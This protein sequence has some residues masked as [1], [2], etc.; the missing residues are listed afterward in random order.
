MSRAFLPDTTTNV[1]NQLVTADGGVAVLA[2]AKI[3]IGVE[4]QVPSPTDPSTQI[5][6]VYDDSEGNQVDINQPLITNENG[7]IVNG[8]G[9][10]IKP[11]PS[12][13]E[14]KAV[15][16][17]IQDESGSEILQE[18]QVSLIQDPTD[19]ITPIKL[20]QDISV[21][22]PDADK[23]APSVKAVQDADKA[24]DDKKLDKDKVVDSYS[25]EPSEVY[26][27]VYI[28]EAFEN[29]SLG[30]TKAKLYQTAL[31]NGVTT[32][33]EY[34]FDVENISGNIRIKHYAPGGGGG[35]S[36][37]YNRDAT[38]PLADESQYVVVPPIGGESGSF[39]DVTVD[40]TGLKKIKVNLT[41]GGIGGTVNQSPQ[42]A[43]NSTITGSTDGTTYDKPIS[44][45]IGGG[46]GC[47]GGFLKG[48]SIP[49]REPYRI[50]GVI[51]ETKKDGA[52]KDIICWGSTYPCIPATIPQILVSANYAANTSL[53]SSI[54]TLT[55]PRSVYSYTD[56]KGREG[57]GSNEVAG[58][59]GAGRDVENYDGGNQPARTLDGYKGGDAI[60]IIYSNEEL[61]EV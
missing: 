44:T 47:N 38:F 32:P 42:T 25:T 18:R 58:M 30:Y 4:G 31:N 41:I 52:L 1:N 12:S 2:N 27:T 49:Y 34:I 23:K 45:A 8:Q 57:Y 29:F 59:G 15:S 11:Y 9:Q 13:T 33:K 60:V 22:V 7:K 40:V 3:Y 51:G 54:G 21:E 48:Y 20:V 10:E 50:T 17:L 56:L 6:M 26:N 43:S 61:T 35:A 46:K 55:G 19:V 24:L 39:N 14:I 37:D 16:R 53:P 5:A 36:T 28:N